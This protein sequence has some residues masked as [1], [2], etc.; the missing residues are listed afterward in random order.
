[1]NLEKSLE[2][3]FRR[4]LHTMKLDLEPMRALM[5]ELGN[6]HQQL[7]CIHIAGSNGKGSVAAM[8]EAM[9][10][11]QGYRTG[12]YTSPH[13]VHFNERIQIDR[14]PIGD[15]ELVQL[16][17]EVEQ[18]AGRL[19]SLGHRDVTFFEFATAL[20]F[21]HFARRK[22]D[23]AVIETG[24]GGRL[25]ATNVIVPAISIITSISL[26]HMAYLGDT[27]AK[28]AGEKAGIIKRG[29]PVIVGNV[30]DEA[31]AVIRSKA[32]A[33]GAPI[34]VASELISVQPRPVS[35]DGQKAVFSSAN[36]DYG[37]MRIGL[38]GIH[39]V[40]NASMAIAAA[41]C[42]ERDIG[43]PVSTDAIKRGLAD[44]YWPARL[45]MLEPDPPVILDGAHN[46]EAA[47]ALASWLR[48]AAGNR[49]VGM[50]ASFLTDKDP[51]GF[52]SEFDRLVL[53]LW[54]VPLQ[55]E[56]AMPV[57]EMQQRIPRFPRVDVMPGLPE[58]LGD[59]KRWA[60][61]EGGIVLVTGSLYLAGEVLNL[62]SI[63]RKR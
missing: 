1:M 60:N 32:Q 34:R 28:I 31:I 44:V 47:R 24:M 27:V 33:E 37:T 36:C 42:L 51:S 12:L 61:S 14:E 50:I 54:L 15:E 55:T 40:G 26:E 56:R 11:A 20:A 4:N 49:P 2:N 48:K 41:E 43:L 52:M 59:A 45:Q 38:A 30:P 25:D 9:L 19:P 57:D 35:L 8:L 10:R 7:V 63:R 17:E 6:P 46:P 18:A 62:Y 23:V 58:A 16:I 5:N 29:R 53:R 21:L 22:V 13:L 39:Q 3:L